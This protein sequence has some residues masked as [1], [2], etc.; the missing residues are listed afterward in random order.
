MRS[1]TQGG[2]ATECKEGKFAVLHLCGSS[3]P[4]GLIQGLVGE[5]LP[6]TNKGG[7]LKRRF[8]RVVAF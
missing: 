4:R 8:Q 7:G 6:Q 5:T 1:G 3:I 2:E